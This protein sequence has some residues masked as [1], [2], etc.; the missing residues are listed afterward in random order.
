M[1]LYSTITKICLIIYLTIFSSV[2]L[3]QETGI[4]PYSRFG[5]GDKNNNHSPAYRGL[6]GASVGLADM[7]QLNIDNPATFSFLGLY[8]PVFEADF[9]SQ[10]INLQSSNTTGNQ[11]NS[12]VGRFSLGLP[13][14]RK[15]GIGLGLMPYTTT[16]YDIISSDSI[17]TLGNINYLYN[18]SGGINKTFLGFGYKLIDR[19][20]INLAFGVNASYFFGEVTREKRTEFPDDED[21][22]YSLVSDRTRVNGFEFGAGLFYNQKISDKLRFSIGASVNLGSELKAQR[23]VLNASYDKDLIVERIIDTISSLED[24]KGTVDLPLEYKLGASVEFNKSFT[25]SVQYKSQDW[26]SYKE[27]FELGNQP[28]DSL[29]TAS[30]YALGIRFRPFSPYDRVGF[31]NKI[32]YRLGARTGQTPIQYNNTSVQEFGM[33]FG[34]GIPIN[35]RPSKQGFS[36]FSTVQLG[37]EYGSRG[38]QDNGLIKENFTRIFFGVSISPSPRDKW[39]RKRKID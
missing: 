36:S 24:I 20:S 17:Y 9:Y 28:F 33:S 26:A 7:N 22:I 21:A 38:S 12:N 13:I 2:L 19:D 18:G 6:G 10:F 35:V 5:L 37:V 32:E 34:V 8:R 4:S 15:L 27:K 11:R 31:L 39:F 1:K 3:A 16:G 14:N 25:I 23:N 29:Q 30:E